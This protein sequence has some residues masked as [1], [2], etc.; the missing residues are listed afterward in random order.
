MF[1]FKKKYSKNKYSMDMKT[2]NETL[3]KVFAACDTPPNTIPFDKIVLRQKA[4]TRTFFIG[5][6]ICF[7]CL[8]LILIAPLAFYDSPSAYSHTANKM[9]DIKIEK[10]YIKDNKFI[11]YL[12]G[13]DLN[14][15]YSYA[16][17]QDGTV[18]LPDYYNNETGELV[19]PYPN[20]PLNIFISRNEDE[21]LQVILT[22]KK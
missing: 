13:P 21:F 16:I 10:H 15:D 4:H 22:P 3:Q 12:S 19:F 14:L 20:K 17:T 2:A 5:K 9:T 7:I 6:W 11:I 1:S 18:Y 8:L